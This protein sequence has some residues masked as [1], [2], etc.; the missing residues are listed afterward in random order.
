[1]IYTPENYPTSKEI[2]AKHLRQ[3]TSNLASISAS[4]REQDQGGT[5]HIIAT[6]EDFSETQDMIRIIQGGLGID[7][8]D[9]RTFPLSKILAPWEITSSLRAKVGAAIVSVLPSTHFSPQ[10][11]AAISTPIGIDAVQNKLLPEL[12]HTA[13]QLVIISCD[14]LLNDYWNEGNRDAEE[15]HEELRFVSRSKITEAKLG[16]E[17]LR[18][19]S[20][21]IRELTVAGKLKQTSVI[22]LQD[23]S[24]V[25]MAIVGTS[26]NYGEFA[27]LRP[28]YGNSLG[29]HTTTTP[30]IEI[31]RY[32][33]QARRVR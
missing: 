3:E 10:S 16:A 5:F 17:Q 25:R 15:I 23:D 20:V 12:N 31:K 6:P 26:W 30:T 4:L 21:G 1:M 8:S 14:P 2:Y 11:I 9:I 28:L 24:H 32:H 29:H 18:L 27:R 7:G 33:R 22:F 13:P 19:V